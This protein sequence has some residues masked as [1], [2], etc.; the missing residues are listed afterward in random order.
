MSIKNLLVL[1]LAFSVLTQIFFSIYYS[2]E[3][4]NQNNNYTNLL[5]KVNNLEV[6]NQNL[7]TRL[8]TETSL[9]KL[10][11]YL[12]GKNYQPFWQQINLNQP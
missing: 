4:I 9:N 7:K 5:E 10:N 12:K 3:I 6:N 8:A 2:S 1:L 11:L